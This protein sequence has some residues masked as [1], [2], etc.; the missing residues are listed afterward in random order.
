M[1]LSENSSD[2]ILIQD[3]FNCNA[4]GGFVNIAAV[5]DNTL[6]LFCQPSTGRYVRLVATGP[7]S[8]R[9]SLST[10]QIVDPALKFASRLDRVRQ[11]KKG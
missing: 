2:E 7:G 11:C 4:L 1:G 3:A 8:Q 6:A 10:R 5:C 9:I